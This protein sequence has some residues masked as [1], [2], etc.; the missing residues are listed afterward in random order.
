MIGR[1]AVRARDDEIVEFRIGDLDYGEP[2]PVDSWYRVRDAR[3]YKVA[4][5]L[6]DSVRHFT[7]TYDLGDTWI[8]DIRVESVLA[9]AEGV[10]YPQLLDGARGCP[11]EDCGGTGGYEDLLQ[12]LADPT[13]E[14]YVEFR[15][16]VGTD[17]DPEQFDLKTLQGW[18]PIEHGREPARRK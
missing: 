2:D 7:Y 12:I 4:Q 17:F 14:S 11:P 16:W 3:R 5:L 18:L 8:H 9:R 10:R 15:N 1:R 6:G 13:H